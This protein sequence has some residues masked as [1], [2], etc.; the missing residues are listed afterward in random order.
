MAGNGSRGGSGRS[1]GGM[2]AAPA[3]QMNKRMVSQ[4]LKT[5]NKARNELDNTHQDRAITRSL[6]KLPY[7]QRQGRRQ[8]MEQR[9]RARQVQLSAAGRT[10]ERNGMAQQ[11]RALRRANPAVARQVAAARRVMRSKR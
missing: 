2:T 6:N 11:L 10:L 8:R 1:S 5:L 3:R 4:G 7:A 9:V